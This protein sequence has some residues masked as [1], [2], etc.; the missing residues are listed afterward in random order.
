MIRSTRSTRTFG[1]YSYYS[2][3]Y[4]VFA[5][6][7]KFGV[8]RL[9]GALGV[10]GI[11]CVLWI[12]GVLWVFGVFGGLGI[13]VIIRSTWS[14]RSSWGF[15]GTQNQYIMIS[16]ITGLQEINMFKKG[17]FSLNDALCWPTKSYPSVFISRRRQ[18]LFEHVDFGNPT[19]NAT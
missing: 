3:V 8:P 16:F 18:R 19:P 12:F 11:F 17:K 7:G 13:L 15:R 10:R 5:E 14:I 1:V 2:P 9:F 4:G 6:H